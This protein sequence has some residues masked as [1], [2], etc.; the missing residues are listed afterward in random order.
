MG[1]RNLGQTGG[2]RLGKTKRGYWCTKEKK[3]LS[4]AAHVA[5]VQ[6]F[7]RPVL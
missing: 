6:L 5:G 1:K 2:C 3:P 7:L 4:L